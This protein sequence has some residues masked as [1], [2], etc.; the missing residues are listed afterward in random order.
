LARRRGQALL[1]VTVLPEKPGEPIEEFTPKDVPIRRGG[2]ATT[3]QIVVDELMGFQEV[4]GLG[5]AL[6]DASAEVLLRLPRHTRE[7][8]LRKLLDPVEGVGLSYLRVPIG[9]TDF[10]SELRWHADPPAGAD[11]LEGFSL[12]RD[13]PIIQI[14]KMARR[15]NPQLKLM[16]SPWSPPPGMLAR[17]GEKA[18]L[19][20]G[21]R[22]DYARYLVRFLEA[23]AALD[24]PI[25]FDTLTVQNEPLYYNAGYPTLEMLPHEAAALVAEVAPRLAKAGLPTRIIGF[26]HNWDLWR[27]ADKL[28]RSRAGKHVAGTAFHGYG[29]E[30]KQQ[31][32]IARRHPE[33]EIHFTEISAV[34]TPGSNPADDLQW[35]LANVVIGATRH[36]AR[37]VLKWNL[38]LDER[39]GPKNGGCQTCR[40]LVTVRDDGTVDFNQD[41]Y[42]LGMASKFV[43]PG[44]R[45]IQTVAVA[46]DVE[47]VAFKNPDGS[48][49]LVMA[50]R[51]SSP[52]RVD[53]AAGGGRTMV[54]EIP[55]RGAATLVWE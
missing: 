34:D 42:A 48:K 8:V 31:D 38:A 26:D 50:N 51:S 24:P 25:Y 19:A 20:P 13:R 36:H 33:K 1:S 46:P 14:L 15:I 2:A 30:V 53:V 45:R 47:A 3:P 16:A 12:E 10:S 4:D 6:T 29:G 39:H 7:A 40:G 32:E 22:A 23:Y 49:A 37:S 9:P 17:R 35:D 54:A 28:L 43:R 55:A 11:R 44:A 5:A 52:K 21:H 41:F 18:I 27:Y